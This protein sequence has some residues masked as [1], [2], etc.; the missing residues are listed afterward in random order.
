MPIKK[1]GHNHTVVIYCTHSAT[2]RSRG[3]E[4][5]RHV[6]NQ[7]RGGPMAAADDPRAS[8]CRLAAG[9]AMAC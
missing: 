6:R 1:S 7:I 2:S 3:A 4:R 5:K 8:I 9:D